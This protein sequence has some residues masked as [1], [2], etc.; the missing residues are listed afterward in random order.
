MKCLIK[1][2]ECLGNDEERPWKTGPQS[3][4]SKPSL[5]RF[6]KGGFWAWFRHKKRDPP[7]G[8]NVHQWLIFVRFDF[9][10]WVWGAYFYVSPARY[11]SD[12]YLNILVWS[13]V[14]ASADQ[15][16]VP[17]IELCCSLVDNLKP[18]RTW[19]NQKSN[20]LNKNYPSLRCT[21]LCSPPL[22]K[23]QF[24]E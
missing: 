20:F 10:W 5:F 12:Q 11:F 21:L 8:L 4:K 16:A 13:E 1:K 19:R 17:W 2:K 14:H 22:L 7:N 6:W 3:Q 9:Y 24:H 15:V 18:H 23:L